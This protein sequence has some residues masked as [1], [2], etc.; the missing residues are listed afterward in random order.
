MINLSLQ[1]FDFKKSLVLLLFVRSALHL[2]HL[3]APYSGSKRVAVCVMI[4]RLP[5]TCCSYVL[6]IL[7]SSCHSHCF[8]LQ[9]VYNCLVIERVEG[10]VVQTIVGQGCIYTRC[11][12]CR[13]LNLSIGLNGGLTRHFVFLCCLLVLFF[14]FQFCSSFFGQFLFFKPQ[15]E[16]FNVNETFF[17][18]ILVLMLKFLLKLKCFYVLL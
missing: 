1:F 16:A 5:K 10:F 13:W 18:A 14:S 12:R 8:L 15:I 6:V 3:R 17:I 7:F 11:F 4:L 2:E 9:L